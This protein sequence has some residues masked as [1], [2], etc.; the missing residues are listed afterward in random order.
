MN[1]KYCLVTGGAGYIGSHFCKEL[2]K[3]EYTPVVF[4]NMSKGRS[5][6]VK[7]GPLVEGDVRNSA[8][9]DSVLR[10]YSPEAVFHFAGSI[11]V[12]ESVAKPEL[13]YDNNFVGSKTLIDSMLRNNCKTIIFSSTA[14]TYGTPEVDCLHE[15]SPQKPINPYG[16]SKLFV[17]RLMDDYASAY[18]LRFAALRYFNASGT[19]EEGEIG[20]PSLAETHLIPLVIQAATG[21]RP[22]IKIFGTDYPTPD[23]SAVRDYIHVTDLAT[24]HIKAMDY[25]KSGDD[26]LF[27]NLGAGRGYSV[28]EVIEE[29]RKV[30]GAKFESI[31]TGRRPGD[32]ATLVACSDKAKKVLNWEPTHSSLDNI[33]RTTWR[34][35]LHN[36]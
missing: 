8:D 18:G 4:D 16:W 12:A 5:D 36:A 27:L 11:D 29:V 30:T 31:E 19:D 33:V 34:W 13:Y 10:T 24:A 1:K 15:T 9:I 14:A 23:G 32:P 28:K 26:N 2:S 22:N 17:E 21:A 3:T 35:H 6:F 25:L 7:W 20:E